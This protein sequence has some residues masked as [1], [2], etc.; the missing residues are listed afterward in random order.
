MPKLI[1]WLAAEMVNE[2]VTS[3][4]GFQLLLPAWFAA[5]THDPAASK[6]TVVPPVTEQALLVVAGSTVMTTVRPLVAVAVWVS[7]PPTA[8]LPG[9][10]PSKE[11]V[12]AAWATARLPAT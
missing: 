12:W 10:D 1:V 3:G 2:R 7:L 4:A 8:A 9:A 11:I 6:L 5:R